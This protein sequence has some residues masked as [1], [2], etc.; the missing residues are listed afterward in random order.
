MW[1]KK[2]TCESDFM[3]YEALSRLYAHHKGLLPFLLNSDGPRLRM[4]SDIL[5]EHS[6]VFSSGEQLLVRI[7]LDIW[8]GSGGINFNELYQV[9]DQ[10]NLQT[11][12][13]ALF[14]LSSFH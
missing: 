12:V 2:N 7:G 13:S 5:K 14:F 8:D 11:V 10:K 3:L 4:P 1:N 6:A 9:L